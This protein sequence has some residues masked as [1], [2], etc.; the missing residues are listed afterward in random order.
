[1]A[2]WLCSLT[3]MADLATKR[4]LVT[5]AGRRLGAAIALRLGSQGMHVAVHYC[6]SVRGAE[7]TCAAIERAGGKAQAFC[8][9]LHD[10]GQATEL[11]DRVVAALGG[12]DMLVLSAA[13]FDRVSIDDVDGPGWDR[14]LDLNLSAPFFM[15]HR[16]RT[17]LRASKGN[18]VFITC[19]SRLSPYRNYLPYEVSKA[20]VHQLSKLLALELAPDV[21]VN[22]VAPGT[23]LPPTDMQ[24]AALAEEVKRIPL[25]RVGTADAVADAVAYLA[26]A[27]FVTGTELVVDGGR[28][29]G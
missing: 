29:L 5:G 17:E 8:A 12:L 21:R 7:K 24:E 19:T 13:N 4:V 1:M 27:E 9:D 28:S 10:R 15:A 14:A 11:V 6:Q 16:A 22:A 25:G 26:S 3:E 23:V 20:A 18:I 2:A